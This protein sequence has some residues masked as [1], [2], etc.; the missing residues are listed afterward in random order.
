MN[1]LRSVIIDD[2]IASISNLKNM[3]EA[4]SEE[5]K[6]IGE[7]TKAITGVRLIEDYKPDLVFLDINMPGTD[8]FNLLQQLSSRTFKLVFITA[9]EKYAIQAIKA[10]A[11]DYLLKP[12]TAEDL[13][14]CITGIINKEAVTEQLNEKSY[15]CLIELSVRDGII[16]IKT[17][18]IIRLEAA[19]SYTE[20]YLDHN[21]RHVASKSMKEYEVQLDPEVF[22]RCHNSHLINLKKV[23]RFISNL[24]FYAQMNDDS[25]AEISRKH[26]DTFLDKLKHISL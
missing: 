25:R 14:N 8:G 19:G 23:V 26:K 13:K 6:V 15:P 9:H 11:N 4:H 3:L 17:Q 22:Y 21:I 12:V 1:K 24:G 5:V 16:F 10:R 2:E 7:A 20:F 18:D